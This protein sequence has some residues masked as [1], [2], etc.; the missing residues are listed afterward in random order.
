[1]TTPGRFANHR[2]PPAV[3][4]RVAIASMHDVLVGVER[5]TNVKEG[6]ERAL[7]EVETPKEDNITREADQT[8]ERAAAFL[9]RAYLRNTRHKNSLEVWGEESICDK[10]NENLSFRKGTK[11]VALLDM[12]DGTDLV[13]RHLGNWCSAMVFVYP[14]QKEILASVIGL[15]TREFYV[16]EKGMQPYKVHL[17]TDAAKISPQLLSDRTELKLIPDKTPMLSE[18]SICF[19]GQKAGSLLT[20]FGSLFP[21]NTDVSDVSQGSAETIKC[22]FGE[23]LKRVSVGKPKM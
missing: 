8:A 23:Y 19:Y 18:A 22:R 13:N 16:A 15:P 1:M 3:L 5:D 7:Q 9:L 2:I 12:I 10:S 14:P 20:V 21:A 11:T 4:T 6:D 17:R